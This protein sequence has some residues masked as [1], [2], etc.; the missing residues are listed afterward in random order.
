MPFLNEL[1]VANTIL[2]Q[3]GGHR[4]CVMTGAKNLVGS[5]DTLRFQFGR[6]SSRSN[7]MSIL[8]DRG[9]DTY[10]VRFYHV[11]KRMEFLDEEFSMVHAEDLRDLFSR[12]TGMATSL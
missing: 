3:L 4:F 1:P 10:N 11:L 12:Y 7:R 5:D 9:T 8:L 6:N 2:A